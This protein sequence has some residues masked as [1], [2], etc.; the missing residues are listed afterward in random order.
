M[1]DDRELADSLRRTFR[2][3][4]EEKSADRW[5]PI[6]GGLVFLAGTIISALDI[7]M[8]QH[9]RYSLTAVGVAGV[10]LLLV[11]SGLYGMARRSLGKFYSEAVRIMPE[12]KLVMSGP[13]RFVR[14]PLY[15]GEILFYLSIPMVLGSLYGFIAMLVLI[16]M[17]LYRIRIEEK[18]LVSKFGQEYLEYAHRAKKLIPYIY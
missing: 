2:E 1:V 9:L 13:Y 5:L 3:I 12:H 16:P 4:A 17:L 6:L 7:V 10:V 15:L 8:L 11:G 14:H 18:I